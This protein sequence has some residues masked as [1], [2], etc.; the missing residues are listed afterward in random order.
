MKPEYRPRNI[1]LRWLLS[2]PSFL[3]GLSILG[4]FVAVALVA[5]PL[6]YPKGLTAMVQDNAMIAGCLAPSPP[7]LS[8]Y[9]FSLGPHP[10]GETLFMGYGVAQGLIVGT[11]WDLA[12]I[13]AIAVPSA[14]IGLAAGLYS[15]AYGGRIDWFV[16][17]VVDAILSI[18]YFVFVIILVLAV[19]SAF[20][21]V[22]GPE[23]FVGAMVF[24]MW[25]PFARG[26]RGEAL[27]V[28][29]LPYV[30]AA[31]ASGSSQ[32]RL[33]LKHILPNSSFPVFAQLPVTVAL[34]LALIIGVQ[35]VN[36]IDNLGGFGGGC[37]YDTKAP[38]I[39]HVVP[40]YNYPEWGLVLAAGVVVWV[41]MPG[42]FLAVDWWGFVIPT[43]WIILFGLGVLYLSDGLRDGLDPRRGSR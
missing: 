34:T 38:P 12:M 3:V 13:S 26:V 21:P 32:S 31:R 42:T 25:P 22:W 28:A 16:M 7:T 30:E 43:L 35:Y 19:G 1:R 37:T 10:F 23:I 39:F 9:P 4:F 27:K 8:L 41:P 40:T 11:R 36:A 5:A 18:P 14:L 24:T 6:L 15:G 20:S 2:R 33:T 29:S 17:T